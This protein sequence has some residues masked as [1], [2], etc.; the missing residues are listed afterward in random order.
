VRVRPRPWIRTQTFASFF[1]M[2]MPAHRECTTSITVPPDQSRAHI[3][4]PGFRCRRVCFGDDGMKQ[5]SDIRAHRQHST[6]PVERTALPRQATLRAHRHRSRTGI[7]RNTLNQ[8]VLRPRPAPGES[9][10]RPAEPAHAFSNPTAEAQRPSA[11][12][13]NTGDQAPAEP[14]NQEVSGLTGAVQIATDERPNRSATA[15]MCT[16]DSSQATAAVCRNVCTPMP[17]MPAL[18]AAI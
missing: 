18:C 9:A 8:F 4:T 3:A 10:P 15:L 5:Q 16:P 2:S 6:V 13:L 7:D 12:T 11:A 14:S 17:G 1:E